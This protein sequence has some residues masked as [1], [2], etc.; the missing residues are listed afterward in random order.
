MSSDS[1]DFFDPTFCKYLAEDNKYEAII[2]IQPPPA[3]N[4][5]LDFFFLLYVLNFFA[6]CLI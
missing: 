3:V 1:K 6:S 5:T 2:N 4:F